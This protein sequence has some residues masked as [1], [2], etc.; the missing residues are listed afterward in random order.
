MLGSIINATL[1]TYTNYQANR[2]AAKREYEY[3]KNFAQNSHQWEVKDLK[4]AG[5]NPALSQQGSSASAIA[6]KNVDVEPVDVA[7]ILNNSMNLYNSSRQVDSEITKNNAEIGKIEAEAGKTLAESKI[8]KKYGSKEKQSEIA[9]NLQDI[10]ESQT[11]SA[12]NVEETNKL[13]AGKTA[14]IIGTAVTNDIGN[15]LKNQYNSA[16]DKIKGFFKN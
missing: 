11:R 8:V 12:K 7:S 13:K 2:S 3:A 4:K 15:A 16:K 6:G 9:K 5:L 14:D 10:A 1:G